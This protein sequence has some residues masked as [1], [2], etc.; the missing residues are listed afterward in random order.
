MAKLEKNVYG[1]LDKDL[2]PVQ[3]QEHGNSSPL[4]AHVWQDD[5]YYINPQTCFGTHTLLDRALAESW[6]E[7]GR[8]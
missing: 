6:K 1:N 5:H 8:Y 2:S 3:G 7:Y 4:P